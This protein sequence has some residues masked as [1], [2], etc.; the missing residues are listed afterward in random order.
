VTGAS[1]SLGRRVVARLCARPE[2]DSVLALDRDPLDFQHPKL[3]FQTCDV[4][5]PELARRLAGCD[6]LVHL[7]FIVERGSRDADETEAIN[8]GGTRNVFEAA[9]AAGLGQVVYASSVAAYGFHDDTDGVFLAEEAPR[10]GNDDF[11]YARHKAAIEHWLDGFEAQHPE[12]RIARMRPSIF[13]GEG[14]KRPVGFLRS[15]VHFVL[16]GPDPKLQITHEEDVADAFVLAL[17]KGAR[18]AFN[19]ATEEPLT[20]REMGRAMGKPTLR[21]P[22]ALLALH[23]AAWKAGLVDV[24]PVWLDVARGRSLLASAEKIRKE[25]GWKPQHATTGDVLRQVSGRPNARASHAA[26]A[27]LGPLRRL[28]R[29]FGGLP[30]R[31]EMRAEARGMEGSVNLVLTG[32]RPSRW[33]FTL[34]DGRLGVHQ[35]L[36]DGARATLTLRDQTFRDMLSGRLAQS[37]AMMTGKVRVRGDGEMSF[38]IGG[39]VGGFKSLREARGWRGWLA[40]RFAA[41]VLREETR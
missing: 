27:Y 18:G 22:T 12:L 16:S 20:L 37:T 28:T 8:V 13:L 21:V 38:L 23:R 10:R 5:D 32:E 17:E 6:A 30:A 14:S 33:H 36:A 1:G 15:R 2:L 24:D 9:A 31:S 3:E 11:Y 34:R 25:L 40:R 39:L 4:R 7:A 35:G 29:L 26:K 19:V 41:R